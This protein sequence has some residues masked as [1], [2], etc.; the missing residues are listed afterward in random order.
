MTNDSRVFVSFSRLHVI[1]SWLSN[2]T[3]LDGT[4]SLW[5]I[6]GLTAEGKGNV[7]ITHWI[8]KLLLGSGACYF[9]LRLIGKSLVSRQ[10]YTL[11]QGRAADICS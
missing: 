6:P 3:Q 9:C 7:V 10:E 2:W 11:S 4:T 5:N 8:L 1:C